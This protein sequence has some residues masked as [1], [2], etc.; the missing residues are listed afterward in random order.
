M[1]MNDEDPSNE[2]NMEKD[3]HFQVSNLNDEDD[4][5]DLSSDEGETEEFI[6]DYKISEEDDVWI[7]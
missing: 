1:E 5:V 4:M 3:F 6:K 7:V 2:A